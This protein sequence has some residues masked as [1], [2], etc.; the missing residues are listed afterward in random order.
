MATDDHCG[1]AQAWPN[2]RIPDDHISK[3]FEKLAI[4]RE[5]MGRLL[6][7]LQQQQQ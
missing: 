6:H 3:R 1:H 5:G 2:C 7:A 4:A